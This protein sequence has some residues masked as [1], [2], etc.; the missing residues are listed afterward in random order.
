MFGYWSWPDDLPLFFDDVSGCFLYAMSPPPTTS[1]LLF[2]R[3]RLWGRPL[4]WLNVGPAAFWCECCLLRWSCWRYEDGTGKAGGKA[5]CLSWA[6]V[7]WLLSEPLFRL[8]IG[9]LSMNFGGTIDC[10]G[11]VLCG[12]RWWWG[13]KLMLLL[14]YG[15]PVLP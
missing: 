8:V 9:S 15:S 13:W 7:W 12:V 11:F 10:E 14:L 1:N 5:S 2:V 4:L 6:G 3:I